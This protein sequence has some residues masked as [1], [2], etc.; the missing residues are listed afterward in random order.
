[1]VGTGLVEC[2]VAADGR[3]RYRRILQTGDFEAVT[4]ATLAVVGPGRKAM[5]VQ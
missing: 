4:Q 3:A 5:S 1:M 2:V